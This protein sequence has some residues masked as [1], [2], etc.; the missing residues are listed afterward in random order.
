MERKED[1]ADN[2]NFNYKRQKNLLSHKSFIRNTLDEIKTYQSYC[3]IKSQNKKELISFI[4][5]I[6]HK[7]LSINKEKKRLKE[8][9][10]NEI[11]SNKSK[12]QNEVFASTKQENNN[13]SNSYDNFNYLN[14][15]KQLNDLSFK[16]EN[17]I[18]RIDFEILKEVKV[19]LN[20]KLERLN[21]EKNL[22]I[23]TE[24]KALRLKAIHIIKNNIKYHQQ[25][26]EHSLFDIFKNKLKINKIKNQIEQVKR[27]LN[28]KTNR[29]KHSSSNSFGF[30]N[31]ITNK[32]KKVIGNEYLLKLKEEKEYNKKMVP[33][34][35]RSKSNIRLNI[36]LNFDIKNI[37]FINNSCKT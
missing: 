18:E 4:T 19:I 32:N 24:K 11:I 36:Y 8:L 20:L 30:E 14:E 27:N 1:S 22:E 3:L 7:L 16:V 5:G 23:L 21:Q 2:N 25:Y 31:A 6:K 10:E 26:L 37:N 33:N 9:L 28:K 29:T 12:L 13:I 35:R 34:V 15:K 17:E